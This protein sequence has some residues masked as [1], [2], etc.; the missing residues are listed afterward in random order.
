MKSGAGFTLIELLTVIGVISTISAMSVP[1][2]SVIQKN[3]NL[4]NYTKEIVSNLRQA[5]NLAITSQGGTAH[6]I[7]FEQGKY[8][9]CK[10]DCSATNRTSSFDLKNGVE[11]IQGIGDSVIFKKLSG[12]KSGSG[13]SIVVGFPS[14]QRQ[15]IQ[16]NSVGK[17][18]VIN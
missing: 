8:F 18:S 12:A 9:L 2:Y 5:Q 10:I 3:I 16:I 1:A 17:V 13:A 4:K 15:T 11:I 14:G 7:Y 6:G